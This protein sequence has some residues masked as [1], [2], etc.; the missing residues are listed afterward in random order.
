MKGRMAAVDAAC[1]WANPA[2]TLVAV[3]IALL[4]LAVAAQR[5]ATVHPAAVPA[6]NVV[7]AAAECPP[8]LAPELRDLAGRD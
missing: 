6:R 7:A 4:D 1:A 2:L 8:V 5:W 3:A